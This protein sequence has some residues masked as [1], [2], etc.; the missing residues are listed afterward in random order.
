MILLFPQA[1]TAFNQLI[2]EMIENNIAHKFLEKSLGSYDFENVSKVVLI[3]LKNKLVE[4]VLRDFL[5]KSREIQNYE[6]VVL[7]K[8]TSGS[9]CSILMATPMLKNEAVVISALDQIILDEKLNFNDF[10]GMSDL[11]VIAPTYRSSDPLLCHTL[12]D[13]AG[14]VIQ[15]FEKKAV[16]EDAILGVYFIRNFSD[17]FRHC[18]ELLIK[19]KG[20]QERVF[21][22]SD[23]IN[24]YIGQDSNCYFPS[25]DLT[26]VKVRS[27]NDMSNL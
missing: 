8:E 7:E 1:T 18:H 11:D 21:Y 25:V 17:F 16:S 27:S 20:F 3:V 10:K 12:E 22:T 19:F 6:I 15:L 9:I 13:E 14:R 5:S 2:Q 24:S 4:D 26:Y 23:V